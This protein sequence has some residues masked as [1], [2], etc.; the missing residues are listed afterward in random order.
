MTASPPRLPWG[1]NNELFREFLTQGFKYQRFVGDFFLAQGLDVQMP[2]QRFRKSVSAA[3][4]FKDEPDLVVNGKVIE[5]KSRNLEFFRTLDLP[6][7]VLIDTTESWDSKVTKPFAYL[8]VSQKT[9]VMVWTQGADRTKWAVVK[10]HDRK[11]GIDIGCYAARR[12]EFA[13]IP[14]LVSALRESGA[15]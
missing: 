8:I 12:F 10:T 14:S 7:T 9:G 5:V 2:R 11:R 13:S 6:G 1:R 15:P 4:D 3:V